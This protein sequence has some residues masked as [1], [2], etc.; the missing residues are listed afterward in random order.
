MT[1][2]SSTASPAPGRPLEIEEW[3]N[4]G[5]VH[6]LSK[7]LVDWLEPTGISPNMVSVLGA[8]MA[9]CSGLSFVVYGWPYA[10]FVGFF[11]GVAWHVFDG[12][13]G[14]LARRTGRASPNGE[15]V[16][17]LCDY[18]GQIAVYLALAVVLSRQIGGWAFLLALAAGLSRA[19]Q[20]NA[21]ETCR[22]NY[23]RWVYGA[24]WIRQTLGSVDN[25]AGAGLARLY[26]AI[27]EKVSA[28]DHAVEVAMAQA[29]SGPREAEARG[30]YR[31]IMLPLVKRASLLSANW[32][33][34]AVFLSMLVGSPIWYLLWELV[35][36]N[37]AMVLLVAAERRAAA[38]IVAGLAAAAT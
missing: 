38:R 19:A 3:T 22:R 6:P 7:R 32:R 2:Q 13:D 28:D 1:A 15:V 11:F 14:Q 8:V 27:S 26:L 12:A 9:A 10:P 16:D 5:I 29:T 35:A 34:V 18:A 17:G 30:L 25:K 37:I 21:Y 31:S 33:T 23:R 24:A 4:R 20:A 36:L